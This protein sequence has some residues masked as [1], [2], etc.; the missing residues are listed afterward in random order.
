MSANGIL[1]RYGITSWATQTPE[2]YA[3][4]E[5]MKATGTEMFAK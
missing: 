2:F 1:Y 4:R 5:K 3:R